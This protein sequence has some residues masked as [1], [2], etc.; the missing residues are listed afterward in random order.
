MWDLSPQPRVKPAPPVL[1]GLVLTIGCQGSPGFVFSKHQLQY[2]DG[3][4]L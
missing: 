1:E 4:G 3:K 2:E